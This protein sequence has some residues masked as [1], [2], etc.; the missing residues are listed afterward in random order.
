MKL[1]ACENFVESFMKYITD[2]TS[3]ITE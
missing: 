1:C 3:I 2:S